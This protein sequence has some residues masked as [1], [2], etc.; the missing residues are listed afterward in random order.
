MPIRIIELPSCMSSE[1]GKL[2]VVPS[3]MELAAAIELVNAGIQQ[4]NAEHNETTYEGRENELDPAKDAAMLTFL[5]HHGF[6]LLSLK[7]GTLGQ[8]R[9]WDRYEPAPVHR[10]PRP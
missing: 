6:Q 10:R 3:S 1:Y 5:S 4:V 9:D 8:S 7:D 2:V